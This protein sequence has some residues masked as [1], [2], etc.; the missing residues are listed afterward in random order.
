[1]HLLLILLV[2]VW[3]PVTTNVA[4]Q[5]IKISHY[6]IYKRKP[7]AAWSTKPYATRKTNKY[8]MSK[9]PKR[10]FEVAVTAVGVNKLESEKGNIVRIE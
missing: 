8:T 10:P 2:F 6:A 4:G 7:G 1:M 5:Q 3:D 9:L